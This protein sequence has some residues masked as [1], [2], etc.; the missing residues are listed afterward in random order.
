MSLTLDLFDTAPAPITEHNDQQDLSP[1]Q[2]A[3]LA[4]LKESDQSVFHVRDNFNQKTGLDLSCA[5][6]WQALH[7]MEAKG[8]VIS[9]L[10][11]RERIYKLA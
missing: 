2:Q 3:L 11:G 7:D 8:L 1:N 5:T 4:L 6:V 10:S 9:D